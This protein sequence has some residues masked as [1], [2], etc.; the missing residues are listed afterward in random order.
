MAC[1]E[2]K[3]MLIV[4]NFQLKIILRKNDTQGWI[5]TRHNN[6]DPSIADPDLDPA[7]KNNAAPCGSGSATLHQ[8]FFDFSCLII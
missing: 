6:G 3:A 5:P 1:G 4:I 7:Y 2:E 8:T